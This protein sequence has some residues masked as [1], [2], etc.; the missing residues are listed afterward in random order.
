MAA[1]TAEMSDAPSLTAAE[2]AAGEE[3]LRKNKEAPE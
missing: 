3:A 1:E 2:I